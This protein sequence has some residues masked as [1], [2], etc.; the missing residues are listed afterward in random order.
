MRPARRRLAVTALLLATGCTGDPPPE[1]EVQPLEVVVASRTADQPCLLNVPEVA[2]GEHE[3]SVLAERAAT[4]LIR[5]SAGTVIFQADAT[6]QDPDGP[7]V[8]VQGSVRLSAGEHVVEC[9]P[10]GAATSTTGLRV[11]PARTG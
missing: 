4:V 3:V 9:R 10:E 5:D 8:A 2:A 1:P 7:L 6:T 11:A